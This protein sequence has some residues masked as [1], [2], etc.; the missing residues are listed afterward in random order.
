MVIPSVSP[1]QTRQ[2]ATLELVAS[3]Q[4]CRF[5]FSKQ[6]L[7]VFSS[8]KGVP[9][10]RLPFRLVAKMDQGTRLLSEAPWVRVPSCQPI[11]FSDC[12]SAVFRLPP[13]SFKI[14][15]SNNAIQKTKY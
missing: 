9:V 2:L 8:K 15:G 7:L 1:T 11:F 10:P 12:R 3:R 13:S 6:N 4:F 5:V 14:G